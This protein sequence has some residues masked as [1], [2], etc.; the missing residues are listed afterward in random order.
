MGF[1]T[2]IEI[3]IGT[4]WSYVYFDELLKRAIENLLA[5]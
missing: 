2:P 5:V 1:V 3:I 4:L